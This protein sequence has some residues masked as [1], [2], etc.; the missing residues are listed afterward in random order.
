MDDG[1]RTCQT[2]T[3]K[4]TQSQTH[5]TDRGQTR[6]TADADIGDMEDGDIRYNW[7][8]GIGKGSTEGLTDREPR[9][10]IIMPLDISHYRLQYINILY[11]M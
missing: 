6:Q 5:N 11:D 3:A 4:Q 8:G 1:Q 10:N 7:V 9:C 2:A